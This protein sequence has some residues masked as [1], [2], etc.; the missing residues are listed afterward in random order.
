MKCPNCQATLLL[1]DKKG[2]E[3]D[4][5][6]ECRGIWLDR[7]ELEKIMERSADHYSKRENYESDSKRYGYNDQSSDHYKKHP[8]KKKSFLDDF[9][10]F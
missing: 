8:H 7:G 9:F 4:Y 1:A 6:P 3:I 10:D 2:V 5:C